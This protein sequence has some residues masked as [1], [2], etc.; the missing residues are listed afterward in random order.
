MG[1]RFLPLPHADSS[2]LSG[3]VKATVSGTLGAERPR[4]AHVQVR[5]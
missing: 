3:A 1:A 4:H 5:V 2:V